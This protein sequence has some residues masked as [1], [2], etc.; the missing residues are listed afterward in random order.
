MIE[1]SKNYEDVFGA[2]CLLDQCLSN[3]KPEQKY[4]SGKY[5][6]IL[7][8]LLDHKLDE[9]EERKFD[10]YIYDTFDCYIN[11]KQKFEINFDLVNS[12]KNKDKLDKLNVIFCSLVMKKDKIRGKD[13]FANLLRK[14]LF[15]IFTNVAEMRIDVNEYWTISILELLSVIESTSLQQVRISMTA[16]DEETWLKVLWES[17][18][19]ELKNK[20]NMMN[21]NIKFS[22]NIEWNQHQIIIRKD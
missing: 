6:K 10:E 9:K 14:E 21:F 1:S 12:V 11:H 13:D 16:N 18:S 2:M 8:R 15:T 19:Q 20:A 22:T 4:I 7:R 3:E 17:S 5:I